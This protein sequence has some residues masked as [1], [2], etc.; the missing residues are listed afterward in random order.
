[1]FEK[2]IDWGITSFIIGYHLALFVLLPWYLLN[3]TPSTFIIG[4]AIFLFCATGFS[5][6]FG[7]HRLYSHRA[8]DANSIIE[9]MVLFFGTLAGQGS[10]LRWAH[11][12]RI[13]HRYVDQ[14][15]DP[16]S[17]KKGFWHA[18]LLWMFEKPIPFD[19]AVI[20]DLSK[21]KLLLF[22]HK[23]YTVLFFL[24]S[25]VVTLG[26]GL[27]AHDFFG[28]FVF[29][30]LLRLFCMHH[31]TW[32]INS[33]AHTWGSKTFSHEHT[34][35]NNAILAVFTFGEGYHN[36]HHT[37]SSDYRNGV[38]WWQFDPT[39]WIIWALSK[40]GLVR[41]LKQV[42]WVTIKRKQIEEQT[43]LALASKHPH[44]QHL[45]ELAERLRDK[46]IMLNELLAMYRRTKE[47][48]VRERIAYLRTSIAAE[49]KQWKSLLR[50]YR[51]NAF[52]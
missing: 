50:A 46:L 9:I 29:A 34:A 43:A 13:H 30:F 33:W 15:Q 32:F 36:Y 42:S 47:R 27:I 24:L 28:A 4:A 19:S 48:Q 5:I 1:M 41:N 22:Q 7:Y 44:A 37:F 3:V 17:I 2:G 40:V 51:L 45:K 49:L 6:T 21:N 26:I 11:D 35:V 8:F 23:H 18:H 39:K 52:S 14:D 25:A 16:Y 12:H 20:P 31:C 10:A 38:R